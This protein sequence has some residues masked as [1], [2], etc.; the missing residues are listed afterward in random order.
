MSNLAS[1]DIKERER[2]NATLTELVNLTAWTPAMGALL[3]CGI[4]PVGSP[5]AIPT[6][7]NSSLGNRSTP[8]SE[9]AI[10]K[11]LQVLEDWIE[12]HIDRHDC[13]RTQAVNTSIGP[14]E[15]LMWCLDFYDDDGDWQRPNWLS[16]WKTFCGWDFQSG[17]PPPAPRDLV[18]QAVELQLTAS[19]F[20]R[21]AGARIEK[22]SMT[23]EEIDN[24]TYVSRMKTPILERSNLAIAQEIF[25]ALTSSGHPKS[26]IAVWVRLR[27]MANSGEWQNLEYVNE[28]SIRFPAGNKDYRLFSLELLQQFLKRK[29]NQMDSS[30]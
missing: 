13:T 2:I 6:A 15:Y 17:A 27:D 5:T 28:N 10:R 21:L 11:A 26:P 18:D 19:H 30:E 25:K 14:I 8:A 29:Q 1:V 23:E 4:C 22:L 24:K 9:G 3:I 20:S 16:Y 12:W 7:N